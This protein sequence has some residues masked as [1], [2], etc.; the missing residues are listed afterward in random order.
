MKHTHDGEHRV[1]VDLPTQDVEDLL[2]KFKDTAV[3][4]IVVAA[5]AD[6]ARHIL[7][8]ATK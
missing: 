2:D 6:V 1:T 7:K 8:G 5:A 4:I 3:T